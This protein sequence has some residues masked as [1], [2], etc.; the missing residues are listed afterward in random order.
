[1]PS[2]YAGAGGRFQGVTVRVT[3]NAH[4]DV[5]EFPE[6][7]L[8]GTDAVYDRGAQQPPDVSFGWYFIC[9]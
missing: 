6:T 4:F 3:E 7:V 2:E 8:R 5:P 1:M 9:V